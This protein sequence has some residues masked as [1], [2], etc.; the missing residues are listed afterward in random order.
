MDLLQLTYFC[1]AAKTQNFSKT[2]ELFFVPPSNVSQTVKRLETELGARLFQRE[3]NKITL[4]ETGEKFYDKISQA[5]RLLEEGKAEVKAL[6]NQ[7]AGKIKILAHTCRRIVTQ[8]VET[9][10]THYPDVT[11]II[12]HTKISNGDYDFVISDDCAL[13]RLSQKSLL[14][15]EPI[16]LACH[17]THALAKKTA[18]TSTDFINE[19]FIA[20]SAGNSMHTLLNGICAKEN[21]RLKIAIQSDDPYYVRKYLDEG[22]GLAF[23]PSISWKNTLSQNTTLKP[24]GAYTRDTFVFYDDAR[25]MTLAQKQFLQTLISTFEK[26][27][28]N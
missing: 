1:S 9:F 22:L 10:K 20:M 26:E 8:A 6:G 15:S 12:H 21:L 3:A 27:N 2:A 19:P 13:S 14:L 25:F 17:A 18:L 16:M 4:N 23:V 5:L 7:S 28:A 24:F 11:F